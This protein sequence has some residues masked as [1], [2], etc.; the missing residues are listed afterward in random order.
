M[1]VGFLLPLVVYLAMR[2]ESEYVARNANP[3]VSRVDA[4]TVELVRSFGVDILPSGDLVQLF[5]ACWDDEQWAMHL[6]AAKHTRSAYERDLR[7]LDAFA[8]DLVHVQ[9]EMAALSVRA[10]ARRRY[11]M[12][13]GRGEE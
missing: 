1:G 6:E 4:G 8:P 2:R 11:G 13:P 12:D 7:Q 10:F 3:Y 5:E 9:T